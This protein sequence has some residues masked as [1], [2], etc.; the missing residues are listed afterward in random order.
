MNSR[1]FVLLLLLP[2]S[3]T[4][5]AEAM[6]SIEYDAAQ[7]QIQTDYDDAMAACDRLIDSA[8]DND[9]VGRTADA[10]STRMAEIAFQGSS[11]AKGI[12]TEQAAG[13]RRVALAELEYRRSGAQDDRVRLEV[14]KADAAYDVAKQKCDEA[15]PN[16]NSICIED[17]KAEATR[18][19]AEAHPHQ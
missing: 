19:K 12:C 13:E 7:E 14:A 10:D 17:A 18:A 16:A 2:A 9:I 4:V 5:R 6:T 11:N 3:F 15:T 1:T 8:H